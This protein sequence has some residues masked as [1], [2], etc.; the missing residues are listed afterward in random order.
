MFDFALKVEAELATMRFIPRDNVEKFRLA[1][2]NVLGD[3]K[4]KERKADPDKLMVCIL[5]KRYPVVLIRVL[6]QGCYP[7]FTTKV[8]FLRWNLFHS[9]GVQTRRSCTFVVSI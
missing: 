7:H 3:L 2:N 1:G 4:V 5:K 9:R 6:P 8:I